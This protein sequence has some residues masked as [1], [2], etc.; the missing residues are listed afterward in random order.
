MRGEAA[1]E[2]IA[3]ERQSAEKLYDPT[4]DQAAGM[5]RSKEEWRTA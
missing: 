5:F 1:R 4:I 2:Y 3:L